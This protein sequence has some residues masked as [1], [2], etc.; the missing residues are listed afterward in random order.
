[1]FHVKL[2]S[3]L[4]FLLFSLQS[5]SQQD[6]LQPADNKEKVKLFPRSSGDKKWKFL[7]GLD[8]RRSFFA[9][10]PVKINGL[11]I[12]AEF[13]GVHRFGLGFYWLKR[14]VV[15]TDVDPNKPDSA[16]DTEVRFDLGYTSVFYERVFLKTRWW[17]VAFPV[18]LGGGRIIGTYRDTLSAMQPLLQKPFSA[19]LFSSRV[20]FYP[21]TWLALR[22]SGGY[23]L[24]FNTD[25]V[26]KESFN[27][28]FYGFGLSINVIGLYQAIFK[29]D[30]NSKNKS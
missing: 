22:I 30:K 19:L 15:F 17:E 16:E 29:S 2:Y 28:P 18:H 20:K 5:F 23:R 11:N 1:M 26:V 14:N 27:R 12:G 7:F 4:F 24:T 8:A 13:K 6:S 21:L 10:A 9:G 25:Q 3:S